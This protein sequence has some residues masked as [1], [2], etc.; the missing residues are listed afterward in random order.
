MTIGEKIK[1]FRSRIGIT[2]AKLA[3]LSGIH[4]VSIR[5]YETNKMVPQA[6][7]IDRLAEALG[8]SSF[9]LAGFEN[10]IR[11]ETVGDF[12]GLMIMLIK[13]KIVSINGEREENG[14][15]NANTAQ[16]VINPFITNFFDAKSDKSELSANTLLYYLKNENILSDILKW[17]R[18]NHRYEKCATEI[19]DTSDKELIN[20]L[21]ELKEQKEVVELELQHSNVLLNS[22]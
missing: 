19:C 2:Q 15:I 16:F 14:M 1:Y 22:K 11:L 21:E 9:A 3:E 12:M 10:N 5:K 4:P 7:Q 18:I 6:A 20:I 8:V 17:E 13:T